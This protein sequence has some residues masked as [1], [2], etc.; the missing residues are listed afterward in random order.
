MGE[1]LLGKTAI[2]TGAASGIGRATARRFATE[3]AHVVVADINIESAEAVVEEIRGGGGS[4]LA[5]SVDVTDP[6]SLE[7]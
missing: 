6:S 4:A 3:G 7:H 2:I 5:V 1:R